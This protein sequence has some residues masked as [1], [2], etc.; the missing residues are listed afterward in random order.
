MLE[1]RARRH[2]RARLRRGRRRHGRARRE[3]GRLGQQRGDPH[4]GAAVGTRPRGLAPRLRGQHV[5]HDARPR[6]GPGRHAPGRGR[7][8]RQH[9]VPGRARGRARGGRLRGL[10]ARRARVEPVDARRP[11]G[12]GDHGGGHQLRLPRRDV[13]ADAARPP[14]RPGGRDVV[15][16]QAVPAG[17]DRGRRRAGPR[18]AAPGD[19][20]AALAGRGRAG[21]RP[22]SAGGPRCPACAAS[23]RSGSGASRDAATGG[24]PSSDRGAASDR[25]ARATGRRPGAAARTGRP[26]RWARRSPGHGDTGGPEPSPFRRAA[27]VLRGE[28][29]RPLRRGTG[30]SPPRRA[31]RC[32]GRRV[33]AS[34][35]DRAPAARVLSGGR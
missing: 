13:D 27:G 4:D 3:P 15:L 7:T 14:R 32:G 29:G 16:G 21:A 2:R 31:D 18:P 8:R 10:E 28:P 11:P 26:R 22:R 23:A 5:R 19:E 20:R 25:P 30:R 17:G 1:Q 24:C 34:A 35:R 6:C 12:G 33:G 9:R